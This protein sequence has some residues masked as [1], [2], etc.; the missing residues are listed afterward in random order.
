MSLEE[1]E[2]QLAEKKAAL[3]KKREVAS[4]DM[5][6]FKGMQTYVLKNVE[7]EDKTLELKDNKKRDRIAALEK[8]AAEKLAAQKAKE[9]KEVGQY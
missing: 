7:D 2:I 1:Y 5:S 6:E 3:N 9:V 8:A 4:V